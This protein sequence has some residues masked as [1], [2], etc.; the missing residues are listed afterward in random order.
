MTV[1]R[2]YIDDASFDT[3]VSKYTSDEFWDMV[4]YNGWDTEEISK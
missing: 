4:N 2:V 3:V 1:Y